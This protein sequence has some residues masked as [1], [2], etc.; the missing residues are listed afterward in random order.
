MED[1]SLSNLAISNDERNMTVR[2][3]ADEAGYEGVSLKQVP[4]L[5]IIPA[6]M[7]EKVYD[8]LLG[9]QT[10]R[11]DLTTSRG[12]TLRLREGMPSLFRGALKNLLNAGNETLYSEVKLYIC[13]NV[14]FFNENGVTLD[15]L[16]KILGADCTLILCLEVR[17][18]YQIKCKHRYFWP[19]F[20]TA[21]LSL[22]NLEYL[23]LYST[24]VPGLP[25]YSQVQSG[26]PDGQVDKHQQ[27]IRSLR[28]LGAFIIE[29]HPNLDIMIQTA[30]SQPNFIDAQGRLVHEFKLYKY[31]ADRR[32]K[33]EKIDR[34][35]GTVEDQIVNTTAVRR[36]KWTEGCRAVPSSLWIQLE[37]G[38]LK[39]DINTSQAADADA[40]Y[41]S[42]VDEQAYQTDEVRQT[43][44]W[45][46]NFYDN[47]IEAGRRE[48]TETERQAARTTAAPTNSRRRNN[49]R[50]SDGAGRGNN[51][52]RNNN[53]GRAINPACPV[54]GCGRRHAGGISNC[55]VAHPELR[56]AKV[57][58]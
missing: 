27:E 3:L 26:D 10:A 11:I 51:N 52:R 1:L 8:F 43:R 49:G 58:R 57:K 46:L 21:L 47:L 37:I 7:R 44:G 53:F 16:P 39:A 50:S 32:V 15:R 5:T 14:T 13:R 9:S 28:L 42:R 20:L 35:G 4:L 34:Y 45:R 18:N 12:S 31:Y 40:S 38:Q 19:G 36:L 29:R 17:M 48:K 55:W 24:S 56:S 25:P 22:P 41:F 6:E 2:R 30:R 54:S 23:R 33:F